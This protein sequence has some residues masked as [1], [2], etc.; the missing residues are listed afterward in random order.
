MMTPIEIDFELAGFS[1][2]NKKY[3]LNYFSV[4]KV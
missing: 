1:V 4:E 3:T 2:V